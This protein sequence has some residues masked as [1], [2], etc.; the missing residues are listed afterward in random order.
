M[1]SGLSDLEET[2]LT[3]AYKRYVD[4]GRYH[5]ATVILEVWVAPSTR[6]AAIAYITQLVPQVFL[7]PGTGDCQ[8][9]MSQLK[10]R[11][12]GLEDHAAIRDI[13]QQVGRA[14]Y[15]TNWQWVNWEP[16]D[17]ATADVIEAYYGHRK[18]R[19]TADRV[20]VFRAY[21]RLEERGFVA[22]PERGAGV[23]LT[24]AGA[25]VARSLLA[26]EDD[27]VSNVSQ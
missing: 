10:V 27:N 2:I 14:G 24:L 4:E 9:G 23:N 18:P 21:E 17:V 22:R 19:P 6:A 15:P 20:A 13:Q 1:G 7:F 12:I 5:P 25:D 11:L 3:L 8:Q 16:P 26:N